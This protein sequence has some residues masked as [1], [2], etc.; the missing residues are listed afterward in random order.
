VGGNLVNNIAGKAFLPDSTYE[1]TIIVVDDTVT[2]YNG[3]LDTIFIVETD[4]T[5]ED[6]KIRV[7]VRLKLLKIMDMQFRELTRLM[8]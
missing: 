8:E 6:A 1:D 4:S 3:G 7:N 5:A 2:I